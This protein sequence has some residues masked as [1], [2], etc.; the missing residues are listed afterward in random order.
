MKR[1]VMALLGF[2]AACAACCVPFLAPLLVATGLSGILATKIA[3]VSLD[4]VVCVLGPLIALGGVV[5][6]TVILF[7]RKAK[8]SCECASTCST[9][10]CKPT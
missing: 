10:T 5:V 1:S 4:Y 3:G 9:E 8:Q 2:G 7:R 6:L